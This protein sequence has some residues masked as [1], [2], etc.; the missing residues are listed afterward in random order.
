M[1]PPPVCYHGCNI[2][3]LMDDTPFLI[4]TTVITT[5]STPAGT[6]TFTLSVFPDSCPV[7]FPPGTGCTLNVPP[8]VSATVTV[9]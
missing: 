4:K 7:N 2:V 5:A 3:G 9:T 8:P 6:Y 1:F